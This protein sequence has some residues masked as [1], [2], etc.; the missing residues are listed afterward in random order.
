MAF[1][2]QGSGSLWVFVPPLSRDDATN[3][4]RFDFGL[5]QSF[6]QPICRDI[7]GLRFT[8][9]PQFWFVLLSKQKCLY[10][11][12]LAGGLDPNL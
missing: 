7:K 2:T 10:A 6:G 3:M 1:N 8:T 5:V 9:Q 4:F 12:R 11:S